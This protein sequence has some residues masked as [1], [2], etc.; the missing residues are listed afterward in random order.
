MNCLGNFPHTPKPDFCYVAEKNYGQIQEEH[1]QS[2]T[3][4]HDCLELSVVLSGEA[5]YTIDNIS[6]SVK[7]GEVVLF[8]PHIAHS[9]R[10]PKQARYAD[11]HIG[12]QNFTLPDGQ[13][14][15]FNLPNQFPIIKLL[16]TADAFFTCCEEILNECRHRNAGQHMMFEA[17]GVKL[18]LLLY[19]EL[20]TETTPASEYR[21]TF[22][23]PE[24]RKVVDF[25]IHY[26]NAH[27]MED[28][29]LDMFAKDMYLSQVYLSKIFKEETNSSPINY[30]IKT[31]LAKAK[32]LLETGDLPIN[33]IAKQVGYDDAYHFSKLFKKYY[34]YPPSN[35]RI[36][37]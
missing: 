15:H 28:I 35:L 30:L 11:M 20:Q 6:Y 22:D 4:T 31:R 26:I 17:L 2:C 9:V 1:I 33:L 12:M 23:Y 21:S 5:L 8:N 32:Q 29:T 10:I 27:Y 14:D 34:G 3:H 13:I 37:K 19:R 25:M 16:K 24:K 36:S 7:R 18:F